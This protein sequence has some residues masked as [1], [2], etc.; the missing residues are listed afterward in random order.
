MATIARSTAT[1]PTPPIGAATPTAPTT[2]Q[3]KPTG[4]LAPGG[5]MGK[6]AFLKLL[7]AQLKNQDPLNPQDGAQMA[8]QLAQFSNVE[9]L[10]TANDT[11]AQIRDALRVASATPEASNGG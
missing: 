6:E 11:L 1:A 2:A 5:E 4:A 8:T 7:V 3:P 9:Q 10:V